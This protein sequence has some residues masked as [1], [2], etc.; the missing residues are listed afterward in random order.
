MLGT[1]IEGLLLRDCAEENIMLNPSGMYPKGFHPIQINQSRDFKEKPPRYD[2][3]QRPPR[4]YLIHSSSSRQYNTRNALDKPL[5]DSDKSPPEHLRL[6]RRCNPFRT[7]IY[8][9]GILIRVRFMEVIML[10]LVYY[11]MAYLTFRNTMVSILW[12]IL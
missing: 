11:L 10:E 4:Y 2:R 3:T 8:Y 7:D 5:R 6:R 1:I 9:L 12:R